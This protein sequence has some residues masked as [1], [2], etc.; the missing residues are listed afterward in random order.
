MEKKYFALALL[1]LLPLNAFAQPFSN[2]YVLG[3]SL[4]DQGNLFG[5]TERASGQGIPASDHYF[6]GRFSNG[7]SSFGLLAEN[8]GLSLSRS[9]DGGTN[10]AYGGA[11]TDYNRV[12]TSA[13]LGGTL[14]DDLFPWT[15]RGQVSAF[16]SRN[17]YDPNALFVVW[18]GSNDLADLV[19]RSLRNGQASTDAARQNVVSGVRE[20]IDAFIAAG[21]QNILVPNIANLGVVPTV[22][23]NDVRFA[24]GS[25][26]LTSTAT[27]LVNTY[28]TELN[29]MLD[30]FVGVNIVKFDT[31]ALLDD[32]VANP[33]AFGFNNVKQ[34]CYSGFVA[35]NDGTKTVCT[36]PD[37]YIFWDNEHPTVAFNRLLASRFETAAVPEPTTLLLF[38]FGSLYLLY[39]KGDPNN[40]V[41]QRGGLGSRALRLLG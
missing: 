13:G 5:A 28:N 32:L 12:E 38:L 3:D 11:R 41:P 31:F 26:L 34:G 2:L 40:N 25:G 1:A 30:S 23:E 19:G 18:S 17:Y 14:Q 35:P 24:G 8:L 20:A 27:K 29:A 4:S 9:L 22:I 15:L 6:N 7:E 36:D 21:A 37:K 33:A 10:F 39:A 16:E